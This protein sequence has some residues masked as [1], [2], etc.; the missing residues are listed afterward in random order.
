MVC[1]NYMGFD[2]YIYIVRVT[3]ETGEVNDFEFGN[4]LHAQEL[5]ESQEKASILKYKDGQETPIEYT[6]H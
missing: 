1:T 4:L 3:D 2:D 5:Y 6:K